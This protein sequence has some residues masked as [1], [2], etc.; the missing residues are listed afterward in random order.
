MTDEMMTVI[1]KLIMACLSIVITSYVI[2]WIKNK[3]KLD[4]YAELMTF[5]EKCVQAA[6]K[7]YT[8]DEW[9]FK[10]KYV[11]AMV[12]NKLESLGIVVNDEEINALIEGF[13]K[14][15]KK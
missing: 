4:K 15:V 2:P 14:E 8:P 3:I 6:E 10:K 13:V 7:L 9:K 5:T 11:L 1:F 12:R